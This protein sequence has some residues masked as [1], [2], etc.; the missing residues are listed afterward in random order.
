MKGWPYWFWAPKPG[1]SSLPSASLVGKKLSRMLRLVP[2]FRLYP[3][4]LLLILSVVLQKK[5]IPLWGC[6]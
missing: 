2:T 6:S 4:F 1:Q 3:N 5:F